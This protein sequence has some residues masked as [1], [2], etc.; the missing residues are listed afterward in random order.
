M[1]RHLWAVCVLALVLGCGQE[2]DATEGSP[3]GNTAP[4]GSAATTGGLTA[5]SANLA[6]QVRSAGLTLRAGDCLLDLSPLAA[7]RNLPSSSLP[8]SIEARCKEPLLL[9][10]PTVLSGAWTPVPHV[11]EAWVELLKQH[12]NPPVWRAR[13]PLPMLADSAPPTIR[14]NDQLV[15]DWTEESYENGQTAVWWDPGRS[16]LLA[17]GQERPGRVSL[18]AW[19]D[20]KVEFGSVERR[21]F[22]DDQAAAGATLRGHF[23]LD[24][25][26]LDGLLLPA[27]GIWEVQ[28]DDLQAERLELSV[29]LLD[30]AWLESGSVLHRSR[31]LTDGVV[32]AVEV[33]SA[34]G[35][36]ERLW[37]LALDGS[38]AGEPFRDGMVDLSAYQG[39]ALTLRLITEPG[40]AGSQFFDYAVWGGLRLRGSPQKAPAR[41]HV[42]LVDVDTLRADRMGAYNEASKLTPQL[43]A[44]VANHAT[45]FTDALSVASWTLPATV[46]MLTGLA[47]HQHGVERAT[48]ALGSGQP[49]V[50]RML[51]QSGYETLAVASGGYLRPAFGLAQ[52]FDRYRT[53]EPENLDF[54]EALGWLADRHSERPFF[55]FVHTY[56]VHAPYP[57]DTEHVD[58]TYDGPFLGVDVDYDNLMD[59]YREGRLDLTAGDRAYVGALYDGLVATMDGSI[60]D[61]IAQVSASVGGEP[62]LVIFTSDH[63]EALFEHEVLGHGQEIYQELLSVPLLIQFPQGM[64]AQ[65]QRD[66]PASLVDIVPTILDVVGLPIPE[67]LAGR[68][69]VDHQPKQR[70]RVAGHFAEEELRAVMSAGLKLIERWPLGH[71][72]QLRQE[73]YDLS[74]DPGELQPLDEKSDPRVP[75][76]LHRLQAYEAEHLAPDAVAPET[77]E[78]NREAMEQLRA[79]GYLGDG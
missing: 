7:V 28:V 2:P 67:A 57:F 24:D 72:D 21:L 70:V 76:L 63:G 6:A 41:P 4:L 44:W 56:V 71:E 19:V 69:L 62:L 37:S 39:Q 32:L 50:A 38:A 73:L 54:S 68:S 16:S 17:V 26:R 14:L 3:V 75:A 1:R 40:D 27:P 29:G 78:L 33:V 77:A 47:V 5:A 25:L 49:T 18:D 30:Q 61:L 34:S 53:A 79:L 20:P 35:Q 12:G 11:P 9:R 36:A 13:A 55:L 66:D 58:P 42:L 60:S 22:L 43:D 8:E 10:S 51:R 64:Q 52:G 46:S 31:K 48:G 45:V 23:S 65:E 74:A 59:P 15:S